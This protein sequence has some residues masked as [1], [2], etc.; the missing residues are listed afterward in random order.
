MPGGEDD[1]GGQ[2]DPGSVPLEPPSWLDPINLK[3]EPGHSTLAQIEADLAA[4]NPDYDRNDRATSENCQRGVVAYDMRARDYDVQAERVPQGM[5]D[6]TVTPDWHTGAILERY[7]HRGRDLG[8][9]AG[10]LMES[11]PGQILG[12]NEYTPDPGNVVP[13]RKFGFLPKGKLKAQKAI[14]TAVKQWGPGSRGFVVVQWQAGSGH[15]FI[16]E[17]DNGKVVYRDPQTN[18]RDASGHWDR[19]KQAQYTNAILRVDDL[20]PNEKAATW[21]KNSDGS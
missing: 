20:T 11:R 7:S 13:R 2:F 9:S 5:L 3:L 21:I 4:T 8:D 19:V 15:V 6:G 17:N 14:E 16:V 1:G 18:N 12:M 10:S